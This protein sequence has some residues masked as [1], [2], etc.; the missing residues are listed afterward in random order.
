MPAKAL[1]TSLKFKA[2]SVARAEEV[3]K[4]DFFAALDKVGSSMRAMLF[5]FC[6]GGGDQEP[7]D[8]FMEEKGIKELVMLILDG[9]NEAGFL[10]K[11]LDLDKIRATIDKAT[12][13]AAK[14]QEALL[15]TGEK[16]ND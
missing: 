10:E 15:N 5:L 1:I 16:T 6:A 13:E 3:Y 8:K 11:K 14:S 4:M 9:V 12:A 7:F 2:S